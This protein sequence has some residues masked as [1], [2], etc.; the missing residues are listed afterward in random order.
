MGL[1]INTPYVNDGIDYQARPAAQIKAKVRKE[2][3]AAEKQAR[4]E[5]KAGT[6][7]PAA[8]APSWGPAPTVPKWGGDPLVV[9]GLKTRTQQPV[10][11]ALPPR[12]AGQIPEILAGLS[13]R[14]HLLLS[15]RLLE[16]LD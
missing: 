16:N 6:P 14:L 4:A 15:C 10:D 12:G 2:A 7:G 13:S 9:L 5:A 11:Q 8:S 3:Q 1:I